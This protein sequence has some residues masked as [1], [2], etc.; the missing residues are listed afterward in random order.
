[1]VGAEMISN[2][3]ANER[4]NERACVRAYSS[5]YFYTIH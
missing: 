5:H 4:A 1:L 3:W 2:R